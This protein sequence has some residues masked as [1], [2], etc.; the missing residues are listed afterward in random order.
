MIAN[1][2]VYV[3]SDYLLLTLPA[4]EEAVVESKGK[5]VGVESGINP[6]SI[7]W[8]IKKLKANLLILTISDEECCQLIKDVKRKHPQV[9]IITITKK[10]RQIPRIIKTKNVQAIL[11]VK[12]DLQLLV[13]AIKEVTIG[14]RYYSP[15]VSQEMANEIAAG[16]TAREQEIWSLRSQDKTRKQIAKALSISYYTVSTHIR[17]IEKKRG[18]EVLA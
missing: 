2:S 11:F 18:T 12:E 10:L 7:N 17:N 6:V 16:L 15:K 14:N 9:V 1:L 4:I 13:R 3:V 8:N 5:V